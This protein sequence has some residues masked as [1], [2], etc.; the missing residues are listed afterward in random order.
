MIEIPG[1]KAKVRAK[2]NTLKL[3]KSKKK[4]QGITD[5]V[6]AQY[7][8][9]EPPTSQITEYFHTSKQ[10]EK[11]VKSKAKAKQSAK[12]SKRKHKE[13]DEQVLLLSPIS[14]QR[15]IE[16]QGFVFGTCSQ[17]EREGYSDDE[18][19]HEIDVDCVSKPALNLDHMGSGSHN[20]VPIG[21]STTLIDIQGV[22]RGVG[23]WSAANRDLEGGLMED[24]DLS[25]HIGG[26]VEESPIQT[27]S[28][29]TPLSSGTEIVT[30]TSNKPLGN[31]AVVS[32]RKT[33]IVDLTVSSPLP[34][35]EPP[36]PP[37]YTKPHALSNDSPSDSPRRT[38]SRTS[39][40]GNISPVSIITH[41]RNGSSIAY[42][43]SATTQNAAGTR[44]KRSASVP[45]QAKETSLSEVPKHTSTL[46]PASTIPKPP[47]ISKMPDYSTYRTTQLQEELTKFGFKKITSR[48]A[49]VTCM[50][51]CWKAQH[52][53]SVEVESPEPAIIVDTVTEGRQIP[54]QGKKP[55]VTS[56]GKGSRSRAASK[57]PQSRAVSEQHENT[58]LRSAIPS[59]R[60]KKPVKD[61][62]QIQYLCAKISE[63]IRK[64]AKPDDTTSFQYQILM[65]DPIILE[66]LTVWLNT[67]GLQM[68]GV[69]EEVGIGDV[70]SWCDNH[71]VC[72]LSKETQK[73]LDRKRF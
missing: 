20:P 25:V 60:T 32:K 10:L 54:S 15:V 58:L 67:A 49:M 22:R 38:H 13:E 2:E 61:I 51:K 47:E 43:H 28:E 64:D 56:S 71:S 48:A 1:S 7:R 30:T 69:D 62:E 37:Q 24:V 21:S 26:T 73:G 44:K 18:Y 27:I 50:E 14:A 55:R 40:L 39:S 9:D 23:L 59:R 52:P 36:Q 17:L 65:F 8:K 33:T 53:T 12:P 16:D 57:E 72:C 68:V 11:P 46:T 63:A 31:E 4:P 45:V 29:S 3:K 35:P 34:L 19:F 41:N 5:R 70:R 6:T 42:F 66:D